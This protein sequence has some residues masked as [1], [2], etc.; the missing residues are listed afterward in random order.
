[1]TD[2]MLRWVAI[3]VFSLLVSTS[4]VLYGFTFQAIGH[5]PPM[6]D[7][8]ALVRYGIRSMLHPYFLLGMALALA[9]AVTRMFIFSR[10]GIAETALVSE[11]TLVMSVVMSVIVFESD[12]RIIDYFGMVLIM[13]GIY[14]V[15]SGSG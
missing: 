13:I 7:L 4:F 6:N 5:P 14:F 10:V 11:L 12:L 15:Q 3:I 2:V 8:D 9:G 1:M